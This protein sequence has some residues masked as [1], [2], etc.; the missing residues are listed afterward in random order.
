M[1]VTSTN[2]PI[3]RKGKSIYRGIDWAEQHHDVALSDDIGELLAKRHIS[4]DAAGS[5]LLLD[6]LAEYGD[7]G[8]TDAVAIEPP[9][10]ACW[11]RYCGRANARSTRSS[12]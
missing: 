6:L 2:S 9:Q 10:P 1:L 8:R 4:D 11:S 5:R 12:R 3:T 7:S